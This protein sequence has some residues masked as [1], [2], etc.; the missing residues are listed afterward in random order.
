[1]LMKSEIV[2]CACKKVIWNHNGSSQI[3]KH[4]TISVTN[5][6]TS[7]WLGHDPI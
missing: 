6:I 2:Y 7:L 1:M 3:V 5:P 4:F